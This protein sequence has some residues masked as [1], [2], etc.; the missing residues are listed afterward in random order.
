MSQSRLCGEP[1]SAQL[2]RLLLRFERKLGGQKAVRLRHCGLSAVENV[3]DELL[4]VEQR[5]LAA[6]EITGLF[7]INEK[8]VIPS[9]ALAPEI[10]VLAD[11]DEPF[12]PQ[13]RQP[14]IAPGVQTVG[15][16]PVHSDIAGAAVAAQHHVAEILEFGMLRVIHVADLRR[17]HFGLRGIREEEKL[18]EL[19]RRDVADYAAEILLVPE[20]RRTRARVDAMRAETDGLDDFADG[21]GFD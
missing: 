12:S 8:E 17:D 16:E 13:N 18:I 2:A 7:L 4:A 10:G 5:L 20:P 15:R 6:I 1:R 19:V 14:P 9:G 3:V 21:S 11:F